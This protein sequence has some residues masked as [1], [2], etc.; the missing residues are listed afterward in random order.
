MDVENKLM[1]MEG[2]GGRSGLIYTHYYQYMQTREL[3]RTHCIAQIT[4]LN[5]L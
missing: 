3:V 5:T 1:V 4:L 2:E